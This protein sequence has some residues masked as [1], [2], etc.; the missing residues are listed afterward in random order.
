VS[1]PFRR[2]PTT[3][4][5]APRQEVEPADG[6]G[7]GRRIRTLALAWFPADQH[8]AAL[9]RWPELTAEG[10]AKDAIDHAAYNQALERTLRDYAQAGLPRLAIAPI[11]I[12]D[13]LAWC[14]DR[15]ADPAT[16]A[17]RA[18]YAAD[19]ARQGGAVGWPPAR[20]QP[21]WCGTGRKYKLCCGRA[22]TR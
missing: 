8:P 11:R 9:R 13:Y 19:L 4:E 14:H 12:P 5:Q 20:N 7:V 22:A 1:S 2:P 6:S 3:V 10:A 15:G 21:C 16:P 17:T 18:N